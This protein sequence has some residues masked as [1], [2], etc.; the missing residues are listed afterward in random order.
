MSD[1]D[2]SMNLI[3]RG[4]GDRPVFI[5]PPKKFKDVT[6]TEIPDSSPAYEV[7]RSEVEARRKL[8][9]DVRVYLEER[10]REE[11]EKAATR[12]AQERAN[13]RDAQEHEEELKYMRKIMYENKTE[14]DRMK[15]T[16]QELRE[17]NK[18]LQ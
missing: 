9:Q 14:L 17:E 8:K 5:P 10:E 3:G 4:I 18:R 7:E 6:P 15:N 11:E 16:V 12:E 1:E 13:S 2:R